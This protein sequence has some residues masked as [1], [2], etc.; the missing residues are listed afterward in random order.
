LAIL[1]LISNIVLASETL[2]NADEAAIVA[3]NF[4]CK[5]NVFRPYKAPRF[6]LFS[7]STRDRAVSCVDALKY[8]I[9]NPKFYINL[10]R[11]IHNQGVIDNQN[12]RVVVGS[13]KACVASKVDIHSQIFRSQILQSI[14][15]PDSIFACYSITR[16]IQ[17]LLAIMKIYKNSD[18]ETHPIAILAEVPPEIYSRNYSQAEYINQVINALKEQGVDLTAASKDQKTALHFKPVL[19][20]SNLVSGFSSIHINAKDRFGKRPID[21]AIEQKVWD[22]LPFLISKTSPLFSNGSSN[23]RGKILYTALTSIPDIHSYYI[24]RLVMEAPPEEWQV[25]DRSGRK[26]I[27]VKAL[28]FTNK[29]PLY[30]KNHVSVRKEV[31]DRALAFATAEDWRQFDSE[32]SVYPIAF[33]PMFQNPSTQ[34]YD[35]Y[36]L[37]ILNLMPEKINEAEITNTLLRILDGMK[38][39]PNYKINL[40][41][42]KNFYARGAKIRSLSDLQMSVFSFEDSGILRFF[43]NNGLSLGEVRQNLLSK[44]P[45]SH[46]ELTRDQLENLIVFAQAGGNYFDSTN[47]SFPVQR[48]LSRLSSHDV[49]RLLIATTNDE[50]IRQIQTNE[51]LNQTLFST[52]T[53]SLEFIRN[54]LAAPTKADRDAHLKRFLQ[55]ES[56]AQGDLIERVTY[57]GR[58]FTINHSHVSAQQSTVLERLVQLTP[59]SARDLAVQHANL[60]RYSSSALSPNDIQDL[61]KKLDTWVARSKRA[62]DLKTAFDQMLDSASKTKKAIYN[63]D[64]INVL[65]SFK[66]GRSQCYSGS[67]ILSM[68]M[69]RSNPQFWKDK[70]AVMIFKE[71]HV[72]PGFVEMTTKRLVGF[73][74]TVDGPG[75]VEFGVAKDWKDHFLVVTLEEFYFSELF[76]GAFAD[77][78]QARKD[79]V[80]ISEHR[81]SVKNQFANFPNLGRNPRPWPLNTSLFTFGN[82]TVAAGDQVKRKAL[83]LKDDLSQT[84]ILSPPTVANPSVTTPNRGGLRAGAVLAPDPKSVNEFQ[85]Q[86]LMQS[87]FHSFEQNYAFAREFNPETLRRIEQ[88]S[89]APNAS[90]KVVAIFENLSSRLSE[91]PPREPVYL[92]L[93]GIFSFWL[94]PGTNSIEDQSRTLECQVSQNI[95]SLNSGKPIAAVEVPVLSSGNSQSL[96]LL[97]AFDS[98]ISLDDGDD[99]SSQ[100]ETLKN[101][102]RILRKMDRA[103]EMKRTLQEL[104]DSQEKL[105]GRKSSLLGVCER[106]KTRPGL[107]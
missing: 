2:P 40:N 83:T 107:L 106:L 80:E 52:K 14:I 81:L 26:N 58:T 100:N 54:A 41:S 97:I 91:I 23:D 9:S 18:F 90:S 99:S 87:L 61:L 69:L 31:I 27:V 75:R 82:V 10:F 38:S 45:L 37:R 98:L 77:L 22:S 92:A 6:T 88:I 5:D 86:N 70:T 76:K 3:D 62:E 74:T 71:G 63:L 59:F 65:N 43:I 42:I 36:L 96:V 33:L 53:K 51:F 21:V 1:L 50:V 68:M 29:Q 34:E 93:N 73:E 78:G 46:A 19:E 17:D 85:I 20:N 44:T 35:A 72:L 47:P 84:Q 32:H 28:L 4:Y 15:A 30:S 8:Q 105:R 101:S 64:A 7:N 89:M 39:A 25:Y 56:N 57:E 12:V 49:A 102:N 95:L 104:I 60:N 24:Y 79:L 11:Q 16:P 48:A 66:D 103:N 55:M 67:V 13:V 94:R